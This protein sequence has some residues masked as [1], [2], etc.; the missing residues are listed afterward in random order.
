MK[1]SHTCDWT[2]NIVGRNPLRPLDLAREPV[3]SY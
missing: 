1:G 3:C 2:P